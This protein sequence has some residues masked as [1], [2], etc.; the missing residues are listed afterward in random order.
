MAVRSRRRAARL[1]ALAHARHVSVENL[2]LIRPQELTDALAVPL[3]NLAVARAALLPR[4]RLVPECFVLGAALPDD[5]LHL[6]ALG[7]VEPERVDELGEVVSSAPHEGTA[8][9]TLHPVAGRAH[10][11]SVEVER[12]L[13][14]R[15]QE[16]ADALAVLLEN[17]AVARAQLVAGEP[18]PRECFVLRAALG[19]DPADLCGLGFVEP[20]AAD[21]APEATLEA[22]VRG[23]RA[24]VARAM[25]V[26]AAEA[27][28]GVAAAAVVH[29]CAGA[30]GR[31]SGGRA[32]VLREGRGGGERRGEGDHE[33]EAGQSHGGLLSSAPVTRP[34]AL[35]G[36]ERCAPCETLKPPPGPLTRVA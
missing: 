5:L 28:S 24:V 12:P 29:A 30:R 11:L 34:F 33:E 21:D 14:I 26:K 18:L 8:L 20:E 1:E 19:H 35:E 13:L 32:A 31:T 36:N 4:H 25:V 23:A 27:T 16:R 2:L 6:G 3:E 22:L 15:T 10:A 17:L 7:V 9:A